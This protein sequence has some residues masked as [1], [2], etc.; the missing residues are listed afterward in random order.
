MLD[1]GTQG[2]AVETERFDPLGRGSEGLPD[3]V[4]VRAEPGGLRGA[5]LESGPDRLE[6]LADET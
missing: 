2:A 6:P 1:G 5:P 3:G 4:R